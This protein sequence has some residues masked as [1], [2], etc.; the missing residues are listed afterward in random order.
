M[1]KRTR[2]ALVTLVGLAAGG[3]LAASPAGAGR[4]AACPGIVTALDHTD[5]TAGSAAVE[6]QAESH[7]IVSDVNAK[8]H[9]VPIRWN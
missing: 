4:D 7:C 9:I 5:G 1:R 8:E 3:L 6:R 2:A